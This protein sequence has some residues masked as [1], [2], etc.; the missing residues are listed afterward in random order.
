MTQLEGVGG[1]V[2]PCQL[3]DL[4][5]GKAPDFNEYKHGIKRF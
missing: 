1:G 5:K 2:I 3:G 4:V